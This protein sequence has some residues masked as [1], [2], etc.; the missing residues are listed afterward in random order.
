MS[1]T[2]FNNNVNNVQSLANRPTQ[3]ANQL[4]E[5]F[6]KAGVDIKA[7]LNNVLTEQ[8]DNLI[9]QKT[10]EINNIKSNEVSLYLYN[11]II[12]SDSD[13]HKYIKIPLI[14]NIK[15]GT[16]LS[17]LNNS[18]KIGAGVQ[19][20]RV[21]AS[22]SFQPKSIESRH[23]RV[24]KNDDVDNHTVVW[25]THTNAVTG[26]MTIMCNYEFPVEEGDTLSLYVYGK[27]QDEILGSH[28]GG[29]TNFAVRVID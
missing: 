11:T 13:N 4:K 26:R 3:N 25:Q 14:E 20:V 19:N 22:V 29:I 2:K 12:I 6:D 7:Y 15:I 10:D 28:Y 21:D 27:S 16:K 18:I 8:I 1:L 23:I 9:S 24:V 5:V 17:I